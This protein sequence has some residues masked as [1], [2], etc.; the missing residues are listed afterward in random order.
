MKS[1]IKDMFIIQI[2]KISIAIWMKILIH[3]MYFDKG[4]HFL[5]YF[6]YVIALFGMSSQNVS[7]TL[8]LA[9]L[10]AFICYSLG[11]IVYHSNCILAEN[12]INNKYNLFV[13]EMRHHIKKRTFK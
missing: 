10:Y 9:F 2:R 1:R 11:W 8:I 4:G 13:K 6:L 5:K 7:Y 12:E 3:K